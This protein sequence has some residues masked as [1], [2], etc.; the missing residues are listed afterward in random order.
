MSSRYEFARPRPERP[1]VGPWG[2]RLPRRS[3][4]AVIAAFSGVA[5]LTAA[6]E[7][8]FISRI[9]AGST[10]QSPAEVDLPV[11]PGARNFDSSTLSSSGFYGDDGAYERR[12]LYEVP[13]VKAGEVLD[14]YR[15]RLQTQGWNPAGGVILEGRE[16]R[17]RLLRFRNARTDRLLEVRVFAVSS[18]PHVLK[19]SLSLPSVRAY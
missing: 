8:L 6:L 19:V 12:Y 2:P 17:G 13:D 4:L 5:L 11:L 1:P 10:H 14:F 15:R 18:S 16:G 3:L 9:P 7:L